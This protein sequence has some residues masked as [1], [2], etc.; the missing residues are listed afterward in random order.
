M[1]LD[2]NY[3]HSNSN[4]FRNKGADLQLQHLWQSEMNPNYVFTGSMWEANELPQ[5]DRQLLTIKE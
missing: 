1:I 5:I 4:R 3:Q 2:N